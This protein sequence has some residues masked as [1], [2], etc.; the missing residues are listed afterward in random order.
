MTTLRDVMRG[1]ISGNIAN[2]HEKRV[3]IIG[4]CQVFLF[5]SRGLALH[6]SVAAT[7]LFADV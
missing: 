4:R 2:I 6:T 7:T 1:L 3:H 5:L